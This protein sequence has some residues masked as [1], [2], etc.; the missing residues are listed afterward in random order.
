[1]IE[2]FY[3][4]SSRFFYILIDLDLHLF[5]FWLERKISNLE[6]N[7]TKTKWQF[8]EAEGGDWRRNW[9][10]WNELEPSTL[11]CWR[12]IINLIVSLEEVNGLGVGIT[13]P[14]PPCTAWNNPNRT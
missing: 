1:L 14:F 12:F 9:A 3:V 13:I 4:S 11:I 6:R 5:E 8:E 2:I 7:E 10:A